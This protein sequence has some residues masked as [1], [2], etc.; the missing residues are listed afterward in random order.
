[1]LQNFHH[2]RLD[3]VVEFS[4]RACNGYS[5]A[6]RIEVQYSMTYVYTQNSLVESLIKRIK[7]IVQSL[8]HNCN[9]PITYHA[10]LHAA[11][12]RLHCVCIDFTI[13]TYFNGPPQKNGNLCEI[14]FPVHYKKP[15]PTDWGFIYILIR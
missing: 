13:T 11:K 15:R 1:M 5:M 12:I 14:S 9:F 3:N 8:L 7:L 10:V 4:S 6:Q 2:I